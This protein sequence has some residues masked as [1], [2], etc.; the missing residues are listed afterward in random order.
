M[1]IHHQRSHSTTPVQSYC[2]SKPWYG[3]IAWFESWEKS[4]DDYN[5]FDDYNCLIQRV[6]SYSPIWLSWA[7]LFTA[8]AALLIRNNSAYSWKGLLTGK[9]YR[10]LGSVQWNNCN[11]IRGFSLEECLKASVLF[12]IKPTCNLL[13]YVIFYI[14]PNWYNVEVQGIIII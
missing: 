11:K 2:L 8:I 4:Y 6:S 3:A 1:Q 13:F 7:R 10:D 14:K 12:C 5:C 9:K